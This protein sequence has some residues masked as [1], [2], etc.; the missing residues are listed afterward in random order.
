[1]VARSTTSPPRFAASRPES[2]WTT[3]Q[4][5]TVDGGNTLHAFIN[6]ATLIPIPDRPRGH[7]RR[8]VGPEDALMI[9]PDVVL[10]IA[11]INSRIVQRLR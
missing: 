10:E 3:G 7:P 11:A 4:C 1:M 2:S 8:R 9:E 5:L 6:Y